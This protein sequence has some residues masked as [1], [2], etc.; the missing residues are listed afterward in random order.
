MIAGYISYAFHRVGEVT[1]SIAGIDRIMA[2]G[3]NWAPPSGL[4]DVMGRRRTLELSEKAEL[5]V[6]A[7]LQQAVSSDDSTPLF[8]EPRLSLGKY[9]VA[10]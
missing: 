5:P 3:F 8:D 4:V 6:P 1:E 7:A 2:G 9:F 10:R